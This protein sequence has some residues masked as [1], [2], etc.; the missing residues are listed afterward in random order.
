MPASL[1]AF[2]VHE[3][4]VVALHL[5]DASVAFALLFGDGEYLVPGFEEFAVLVR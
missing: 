1:R 3:R 5:E 4:V 2:F